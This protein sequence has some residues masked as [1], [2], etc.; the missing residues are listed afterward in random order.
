MLLFNNASPKLQAVWDIYVA[1]EGEETILQPSESKGQC[2]LGYRVFLNT[3][4]IALVYVL[5]DANLISLNRYSFQGADGKQLQVEEDYVGII[6]SS[7]AVVC[8][9]GQ[10]VR[11][12]HTSSKLVVQGEV[13]VDDV[14]GPPGLVKIELL[15][16]PEVL[17]KWH[18]SSRKPDDG[19]HLL[20]MDLII[21]FHGIEAL[22]VE[23]YEVPLLILQGLLRQDHTSCKVGAVGLDT[24]GTVI[25]REYEDGL[26]GDSGLEGIKGPLLHVFPGPSHILSGEVKERPC[27]MGEV[28]DEPLVEVGELQEGLYFL[29][30]PGLQPLSNTGHLHWV[31]LCHTMRD[32]QP[33]V[34]N[35]GLLKLALLQFE[36]ELVLVEVLQDNSNDVLMLL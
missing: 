5:E 16:H 13:E 1:T 14:Q 12:P 22:G 31:H 28:L 29:L 35:L 7:R 21:A 19:Q 36:I 26:G 34:L 4:A 24:E 2:S 32:D 20:V 3:L 6:F 33:E 15:G 8:M 9:S 25:V 17:Q 11:L 18:H 30:V 27:M 10:C 23:C